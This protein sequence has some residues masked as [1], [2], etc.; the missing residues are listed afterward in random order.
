MSS[1]QHLRLESIL[2]F[3]LPYPLNHSSP[4]P[5]S[6]YLAHIAFVQQYQ[7]CEH[8]PSLALVA[9]TGSWESTSDIYDNYQ[10]LRLLMASMISMSSQFSVNTGVL[11]AGWHLG[12]CPPHWLLLSQLST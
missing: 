1:E 9:S 7:E 12:I 5:Y 8:Q 2:I 3:H 4:M 10:Y 6:N 11:V